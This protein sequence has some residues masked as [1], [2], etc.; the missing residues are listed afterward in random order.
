MLQKY[1]KRK[2][3]IKNQKYVKNKLTFGHF[4]CIYDIELKMTKGHLCARN[5]LPVVIR[6]GILGQYDWQKRKDEKL[7]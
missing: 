7:E 1:E 5:S 4:W 3:F 6:K 2:E